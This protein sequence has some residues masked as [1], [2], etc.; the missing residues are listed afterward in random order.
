MQADITSLNTL[1]QT[2]KNENQ[3]MPKYWTDLTQSKTSD[4]NPFTYNTTNNM[5]TNNMSTN[6]NN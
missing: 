1:V 6:N 2:L 4:N 3:S 5:S